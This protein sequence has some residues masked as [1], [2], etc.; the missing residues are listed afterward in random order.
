MYKI[1]IIC[2]VPIY[3]RLHNAPPLVETK[4]RPARENVRGGS[5]V[6]GRKAGLT[7]STE[8]QSE[9]P[10]TSRRRDLALRRRIL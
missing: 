7:L 4:G 8:T 3:G 2:A 10:L 1:Y 9:E 6:E 5:S